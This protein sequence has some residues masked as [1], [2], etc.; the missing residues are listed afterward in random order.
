M[1]RIL[2][3]LFAVMAFSFTVVAQDAPKKPSKFFVQDIS[4]PLAEN[5]FGGY[6]VYDRSDA[7]TPEN[8]VGAGAFVI[9]NVKFGNQ[10]VN[11]KADF[12][13]YTDQAFPATGRVLRGE[14]KARTPLGL[15]Y[16]FVGQDSE[17]YALGAVSLEHQSGGFNNFNPMVG[18]GFKTG[19]NV[20]TEYAYV[21]SPNTNNSVR[22]HQITVEYYRPLESNPN[23]NIVTGFTGLA[24][25]FQQ[26][27]VDPQSLS[28]VKF[29]IGISK[30]N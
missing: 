18:A 27:P 23:W 3:V 14:L 16:N 22:G 1:K 4:A 12:F 17:V 9:R 26:G 28:S 13:G 29:F 15:K 24:G 6:F 7:Q 21:I 8:S 10:P 2:L 25:R 5:Q 20:L 11:L 30:K 19:D